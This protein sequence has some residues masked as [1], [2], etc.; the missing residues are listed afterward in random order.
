MLGRLLL[1]SS[2]EPR[3]ILPMQVKNHYGGSES[4]KRVSW[5]KRE[6]VYSLAV[7]WLSSACLQACCSTEAVARAC[8]Q[9]WLASLLKP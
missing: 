8:L 9:A 5:I 4:Q 7:S 6:P 2:W 1:L 3:I